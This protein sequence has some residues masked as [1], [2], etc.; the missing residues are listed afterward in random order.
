MRCVPG[1]ALLT[2]ALTLLLPSLAVMTAD[3]RSVAILAPTRDGLATAIRAVAAADGEVVTV[4][5]GHILF[6]K[7]DRAGFTSRLR[8]AGAWLVLPALAFGCGG[9]PLFSDIRPVSGRARS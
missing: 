4:A 7:S 9:S 8:A 2:V 5:T 1:P 3:S 6:A